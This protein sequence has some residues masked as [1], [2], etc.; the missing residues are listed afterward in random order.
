MRTLKKIIL[1]PVIFFVLTSTAGAQSSLPSLDNDKTH[2]DSVG[3]FC[4]PC[5]GECDNLVFM[6]PGT[7]PHCGMDLVR[8]TDDQSGNGLRAH[9]APS[10]NGRP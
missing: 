4:P 7:C 5:G 10:L 8:M 1:L 3:Y 9:A 6:K 2:N